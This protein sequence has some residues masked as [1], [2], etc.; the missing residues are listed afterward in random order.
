[1]WLVLRNIVTAN[2]FSKKAAKSCCC[3]LI[4]GQPR[5]FINKC[6]IK[7]FIKYICHG[8]W[9]IISKLKSKN[10]IKCKSI[11]AHTKNKNLK[12]IKNYFNISDVLP[13]NCIISGK[14]FP[15]TCSQTT[16]YLITS[17]KNL[18]NVTRLNQTFILMSF[19]GNAY[20]NKS[21]KVNC[22]KSTIYRRPINV[23]RKGICVYLFLY[24]LSISSI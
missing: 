15:N 4:C 5:C 22:Y 17:T 16:V 13:W 6:C 2:L 20:K 23:I 19:R 11:K 3:S 7:Q 14:D 9:I 18:L 8:K 10:A 12:T 21:V 24:A 1:M